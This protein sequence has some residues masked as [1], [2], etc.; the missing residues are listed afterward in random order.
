MTMASTVKLS[1]K[2]WG[3]SH[4]RHARPWQVEVDGRTVGTISNKETV[5]LQVESGRHVLRVRSMRFLSSPEKPFEADE[6]HVV[7]FSCHPRSLSPFILTRW[8]VWL[9]ATLVKHD[10]WIDLKPEPDNK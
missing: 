9:V 7:G 10:L 5:E 4:S 8:I 3:S 1:R 2:P 6:G